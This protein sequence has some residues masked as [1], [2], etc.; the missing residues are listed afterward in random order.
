[1]T[2]EGWSWWSGFDEEHFSFGPF[3]SRD[4]AIAEAQS[5]AC[6]EFQD[7]NGTWKVGIWLVEAR[8]DPLRLAEYINVE[9]MLE[10][11]DEAVGESDRASED[12]DPPY[13]DITPQQEAD[14]TECI[15]RVCDA[16]QTEH[17]IWPDTYTFSAMRNHEYIVVAH[18]NDKESD[19]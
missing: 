9:R 17:K 7:K 3:S 8:K 6:G 14:L 4:E 5:D 15:K 16:W 10:C 1:M 2:N 19:A 11:A 13:F 12:D 18:P